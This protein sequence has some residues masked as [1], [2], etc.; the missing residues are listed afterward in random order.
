[1]A[2]F[3]CAIVLVLPSLGQWL[4]PVF[5][6]LWNHDLALNTLRFSLSFAILLVPTT[7][8]GLTLPV[9]INDPILR[10]QEF[11]RAMGN[12]Y[13]FNTL[14]AVAGAL[15]GEGILVRAFGLHGTALIAGAL[16]CA[17]A[18][19]AWFVAQSE[20][21]VIEE[22]SSVRPEFKIDYAAPWKLL[23][24]TL[25]TGAVLLCLEVVWFRFL[26]LY[27]ASSSTA[28][29]IMLAVVLAGIGLGGIASAIWHA[30]YGSKLL[31]AVSE[32]AASHPTV[33]FITHLLPQSLFPHYQYNALRP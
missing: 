26:R 14:G 15:L 2:I 31:E 29:A 5:Q 10:G 22:R 30:V 27:V 20:R 25:G 32:G 7:A 13:G 16:N 17:A 23:F 28:F 11:G 3:G 12:L 4:R 1:M 8:M 6:T 9:L 18:L 21:P 24:V 33:A 19:L